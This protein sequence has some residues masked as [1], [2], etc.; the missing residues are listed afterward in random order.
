MWN[1]S[2][3]KWNLF[4]YLSFMSLQQSS[5]YHWL[6]DILLD[7]LDIVRIFNYILTYAKCKTNESDDT[8]HMFVVIQEPI[9]SY[10]SL[11]RNNHS[12]FEVRQWSSWWVKFCFFNVSIMDF[13]QPP[14]MAV[15]LQSSSECQIRIHL[16]HVLKA[17]I[18]S[19]TDF[20]RRIDL[21]FKIQF[22]DIFCCG[23]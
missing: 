21:S 5:A 18:C 7:I 14:L 13:K 9:K 20:C 6:C 15:G 10:F 1:I 16:F 11:P 8:K 3:L 19:S 4:E 2:P 17:P 12:F 23:E 22:T